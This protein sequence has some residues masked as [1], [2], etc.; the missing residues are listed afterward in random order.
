M[1]T[2][3]EKIFYQISCLCCFTFGVAAGLYEGVRPLARSCERTEG[4][5]WVTGDPISRHQ[6]AD[7]G[8][9]PGGDDG[10]KYLQSLG[11]HSSLLLGVRP[12]LELAELLQN[13]RV[14]SQKS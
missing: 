5:T 10:G 3:V 4:Q 14:V 1:T 11:L 2:K 6:G 9:G 13:I 8:P 12:Q 7:T